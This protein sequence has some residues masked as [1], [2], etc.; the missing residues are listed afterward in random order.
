MVGSRGVS[1]T[2]LQQHKSIRDNQPREPGGFFQQLP[3]RSGGPVGRTPPTERFCQAANFP[4][5]DQKQLKKQQLCTNQDGA[6]ADLLSEP[7]RLVRIQP[8]GR[9]QSD[10]LL[11]GGSS[12]LSWLSHGPLTREEEPPHRCL[13][14]AHFLSLVHFLYLVCI[15]TV[16]EPHQGPLVCTRAFTP[17]RTKRTV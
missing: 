7:L 1:F 12:G 2:T 4:V 8:A 5:N 14:L 13:A 11:P 10:Q 16:S 15:H 3:E 17:A 6:G 9:K